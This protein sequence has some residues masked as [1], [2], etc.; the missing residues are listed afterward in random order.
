MRR[1][2]IAPAVLA[3]AL[4]ACSGEGPST[5]PTEPLQVTG[6]QFIPGTLPGTLPGAASQVPAGTLEVTGINLPVRPLGAGWTNQTI[7][8]L[9]TSDATAV[10]VEFAGLGTGYWVVVVGGTDTAN[11]GQ[12]DFSLTAS[13][14]A[15]DPP[16]THQLRFVAI[17][18]TGKAGPQ[19]EGAICFDT[20]VPDN[21]HECVPSKAPPAAV[22]SLTWDTGFDLDL[23]V[24]FPG[25]LDVNPESP[26][27]TLSDAGVPPQFDSDVLFNCVPGG[28][29]NREDLVFQDPPTPGTYGISVDP[30][31]SCGQAAVHFTVTVYV[32]EPAGLCATCR[33]N[34]SATTC[35]H[36]ELAAVFTQSGE[37]LGSQVTGGASPGLF[38]HDQTF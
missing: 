37:L 17:G 36:C 18:P 20:A 38:V 34:P 4:F 32:S 16:G 19:N 6:A 1:T 7:S 35:T 27:A 5:Q 25:G 23:H 13:F 30:F 2:S 29:V 14:N 22:I 33:S 8:G 15:S 26:T 10:G 9:V 28:G 3:A 21:L 11:P 24:Q 12:S 31:A